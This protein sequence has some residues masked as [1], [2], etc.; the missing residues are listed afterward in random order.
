MLGG[1]VFYYQ[2]N[3]AKPDTKTPD[4]PKVLALG[5]DQI[6]SIVLRRPSQEVLTLK[7][8]DGKWVITEPSMMAA[9]QDAVKTLVGAVANLSADRLIDEKPSDLS[10]FGLNAPPSEVDVQVKGG[11]E[12]KLLI[13]SETP[14]GSANYVKLASSPKVYTV[15]STTR[16]NLDKSVSDLRDKRLLTFNNDKVTA[17]S[18]ASKGPEFSFARNGQNEWQITKPKP[19]RADSPQ[20][21]DLLRKLKD[22]KMDLAGPV[23]DFK[24]A[25]KVA[26]ASV[27]DNASTQTIE[28]R[29]A[30]DKSYVAKSSVVE[31]FF[32]LAGDLGEGLKDKTVDSFRNKKLFDFSFNDPSRIELNGAAYTKGGSA[33]DT[34]WNG[35]SGQVDS[36]SIQNVVDKLRDLTASG[37]TEKLGGTLA[38]EIAVTSG[39]NHK[40]EKVSFNKVGDGYQAQRA[41][42]PAVYVL[43]AATYDDLQGAIKGIKPYTAPKTDSKDKKK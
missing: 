26:T 30:K 21:D 4:S 14:A 23:P 3:P 9:D 16:S 35:P 43:P 22:A 32:K 36:A 18:V 10:A 15:F 2:K 19:Y 42:D 27:T 33:Q 39:D 34:K 25:E 41:G 5:E 31:G 40:V 29:Q 11:T 6:E 37:F 8:M 17:I 1:L 13:G 24:T 7:K 28:V 20:V 38:Y 12:Y